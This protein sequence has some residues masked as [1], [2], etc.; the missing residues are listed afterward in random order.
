MRYPLTVRAYAAQNIFN[1]D[2]VAHT[3]MLEASMIGTTLAVEDT[4]A[5]ILK[6]IAHPFR[7][8]MLEALSADEE[9]VCH[10]SALFEKPQPYI[11]QQ[12]AALKEAGLVQDRRV[13]QRI[14]YRIADPR[15]LEL[16]DAVRALSGSPAL[17]REPRRAVTGCSC[18]KCDLEAR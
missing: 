18:P 9:C 15:V 2:Y 13:A 4:Q 3:H 7:I 8:R 12:L 14:F 11:S 6:A 1:C 16:L 10:L 5:Q 17:A